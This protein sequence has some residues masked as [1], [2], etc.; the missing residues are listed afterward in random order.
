VTVDVK[1]MPGLEQLP[2]AEVWFRSIDE[3]AWRQA[4]AAARGLGKSGLEVWTTTETPVVVAFL[5]ARGYEE[6]RRYVVSE[7]DVAAASAP[8]PP[9]ITLATF[10][11]RPDLARALFEIAL[12]SYPDQPGR[13]EQIIESFESWRHWGLDGIHPTR[14]SSRSRESACWATASWRSTA[15]QATTASPRSGVPSAAVASRAR[16]SAPRSRGRRSTAFDA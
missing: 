16:S 15:R 5:A 2:F 7:L 14:T 13:S 1:Q 8:E 6:V 10:A 12:Q 3:A 4:S 9:G 11:D